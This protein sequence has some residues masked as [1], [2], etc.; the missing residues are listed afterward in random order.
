M[1]RS[2]T[3]VVGPRLGSTTQEPKHRNGADRPLTGNRLSRVEEA[4]SDDDDAYE[5]ERRHRRHVVVGWLHNPAIR[6][7]LI[8][9][10]V[11]VVAVYVFIMVATS[12]LPTELVEGAD[13]ASG[14]NMKG[15][16]GQAHL[17]VPPVKE[18]R[19][20]G[21]GATNAAAAAKKKER[22]R[23]AGQVTF[24]G[25]DHK[26]QN[27]R[28]IVNPNSKNHPI[29]QLISTAQSTWDAKVAKQ[30]KT[31]KQAVVEYKRRHHRQPPA[32]FDKWWAYVV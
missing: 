22:E 8:V 31:L 6:K 29:N 7:R 4:S 18:H 11:S 25:S 23:A 13:T 24:A 10:C 3:L 27:G 16:A 20:G 1:L 28:L 30:S 21:G 2:S 26:V 17:K 14:V 15:G 5:K 32:G 19:A 9:V 12:M